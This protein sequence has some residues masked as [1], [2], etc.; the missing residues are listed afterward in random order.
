MFF[1][2]PRISNCFEANVGDSPLSDRIDARVTTAV[3]PLFKGN[4]YS[5]TGP[6]T[7]RFKISDS[8]TGKLISGLKDVQ[9]LMFEAPGIW[10]KRVWAN[11]VSAGVYGVTELFPHE[12]YFR[13]MTQIESRGIRYASLPFANVSVLNEAKGDQIKQQ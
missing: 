1:D 12:G 9:V 8:I 3:E 4:Q 7:L 11:E 13:V 5:L 6:V 10:Q 2:Q